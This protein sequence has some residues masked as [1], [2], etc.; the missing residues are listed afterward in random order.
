MG[1]FLRFLL[2]FVILR[3]EIINQNIWNQQLSLEFSLL[4]HLDDSS[5]QNESCHGDELALGA[6]RASEGFDHM[7]L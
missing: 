1:I 6:Q 3:I 5:V 4:L 7:H 2:A